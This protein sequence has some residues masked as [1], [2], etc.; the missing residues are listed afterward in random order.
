MQVATAD[1]V[2]AMEIPHESFTLIDGCCATGSFFFELKTYPW[3]A[4]VLNDLNPLRTNFL[5]VLR[6]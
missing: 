4:V 3:K 6:K 1:A 2:D 5:N